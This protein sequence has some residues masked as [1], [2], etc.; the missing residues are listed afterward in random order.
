MN[1]CR[2]FPRLLEIYAFVSVMTRNAR[3]LVLDFQCWRLSSILRPWQPPL[4]SL[5]LDMISNS[6]PFLRDLTILRLCDYTGTI[7]QLSHLERLHYE[8][9][10]PED[11]DVH[12]C[13]GRLTT[14]LLPLNSAQ[15]LQTLGV[16]RIQFAPITAFNGNPLDVFPNLNT[17]KIQHNDIGINDIILHAKNVRLSTLAMCAI[18]VPDYTQQFYRIVTSPILASLATFSLSLRGSYGQLGDEN[19]I[20][21]PDPISTPSQLISS[22]FITFTYIWDSL[23]LGDITFRK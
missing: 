14:A 1:T 12:P 6:C 10:E 18:D 15:T 13:H 9:E 2:S 20:E 22:L 16:E 11:D 3:W 5:D 4:N 8:F 7:V 21:I 19:A 17:L 23:C